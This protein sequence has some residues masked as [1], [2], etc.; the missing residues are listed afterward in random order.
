MSNTHPSDSA[1]QQEAETAILAAFAEAEGLRLADG[2]HKVSVEEGVSIQPDAIS[3]DG[4]VVLEA[5]ARQGKL[6]PGQHK[7]VAQDVLKFALLKRQPQW[8]KAR[9]VIVF[10]DDVA[11]AS[12]TGWLRA[13]AESFGIELVSVSIGD[14]LRQRILVAQTKQSMVNVMLDE[15]AE[16]VVMTKDAHD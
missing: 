15:V 13:A 9:T 6:R 1:V 10:A 5:F 14:E 7:K 2:P 4:S 3:D 16:D 8:T 12:V 11:L